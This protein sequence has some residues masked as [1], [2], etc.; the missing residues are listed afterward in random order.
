MWSVSRPQTRCP[1]LAATRSRAASAS[2]A[3]RGRAPQPAAAA[4]PNVPAN[5]CV[6]RRA[7]VAELDAA[8]RHREP[9]ADVVAERDGAQEGAPVDAELLAERERRGNDRRAGMRLRRAVRVVGLVGVREHAVGERG[10][11]RR[12]RAA[13]SPRSSRPTR[14]PACARANASAA[15]PGGE[16]G[17]GDHRGESVE[18][19][20]LGFRG[21]VGRQRTRERR[22]HVAAQRV[23]RGADRLR[24]SAARSERRARGEEDATA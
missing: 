6:L 2:A 20:L 24:A 22:G 16:L 19:V 21:D 23:H 17:A 13:S 10:V 7:V 5:A 4:A 12:S 14:P 8:E 18:H 11:G 9:R 1:T 15:R 3:R